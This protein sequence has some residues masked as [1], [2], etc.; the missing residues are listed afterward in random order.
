ML[1]VPNMEVQYLACFPIE[2]HRKEGCMTT[3]RINEKVGALLI[4]GKTRDQ[5]AQELG[6]TRRTLTN[7]INGQAKWEW[8][9]VIRLSKLV[10]CSLDDLV[11]AS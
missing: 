11:D 6:M 8:E 5:L 4:S 2:K 1:T 7:R 9:E 10:G 3:Q